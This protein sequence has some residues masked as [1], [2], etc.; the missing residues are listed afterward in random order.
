LTTIHVPNT[1]RGLIFDCD[2]TL[3]DSMPL[4]MQAWEYA[5]RRFGAPY[6]GP[7]IFSKKGMKEIEIVAL[8]NQHLGTALD[9]SAVVAEKHHH[10]LA[11][12]RHVK[13]FE[14]VLA[15]VRRFQ[16]VLPMAVVSGGVRDIIVGE[17]AATGLA[18]WF[19]IVLTADD[20]LPPK[21]APD[22]FLEAARRMNV[23]ASDCQVFE[24]GDA[25]LEAARRA[26]M[27]ATDVRPYTGQL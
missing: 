7:F 1:V 22:L 4:H 11:R 2:G 6:D 3:V 27:L 18:G 25:G 20:P 8:Y 21:P 13:P 12:I 24:D 16:G 9:A 19:D 26:G 5:I 15:V 10:F 23:P 17:L 14:P